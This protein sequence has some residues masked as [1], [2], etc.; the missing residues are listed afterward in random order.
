MPIPKIRLSDANQEPIRGEGE[1]VLYW[2]IANRRL[3]WN[4]ALEHAIDQAKK[5]SKPLLIFEPLRLRYSWANE[6]LHRFVIQGMRDHAETLRGHPVGYYP[7]VEPVAGAGSPLL[8]MLAQR[9]CLVVSDEYPCFFLPTMIE[10][11]KGALGVRLQLVESSTVMPLR[12]ADRTFTVA[13][14]YRRW[15]HKQ[16][17]DVILDAPKPDP[18]ARLRLPVF[19]GVDAS[20]LRRWPAADFKALLDGDGLRRM[21]IDHE[22]RPCDDHVG[23]PREAARRLRK[24]V[25]TGLP[26]YGA[27]RNHP[28]RRATSGLSPYLHFG[29]IS[30]HE[31]VDAVL[32]QQ[33]WTPAQASQAYGK[34]RG[35]WNTS[36]S[37]EAFLDQLLTWREIGFNMT[38]RNPNDYDRYE[39]L[40]PWA[41]KTLAQ[42]AADP[43]PAVYS[44]EQLERAETHDELWNAAQRELVS[45]GM[46]HNYL[47][48]LWGKLIL[49]WTESPRRALEVMI[50]LN[51]K[52]GLDGR[53]PNSYS[54][55][56]WTLGRYDRAWG[57]TRPVFG[58]IRY[59]TS[60]SARRKLKLKTYLTRFGQQ[61]TLFD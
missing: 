20:I 5:L 30:A 29:H 18:L 27:E 40:P 8:R 57:P 43:R 42:H 16:I 19:A 47:R 55:I 53:D 51:N 2:M 13:H 23:G 3:R 52:Y 25:E 50:E 10:A 35:F 59:M 41:L 54:G 4:F 22:V 15:M 49:N 34:N 7:Y 33:S 48:M 24:F 60:D 58:N 36:E 21:A 38:H 56:F 28:D 31:M 9:A 61:S 17:L 6:R 26:D 32:D 14:S 12:Q 37:A 46:V 44:L 39:S 1:F 45:T 11:V